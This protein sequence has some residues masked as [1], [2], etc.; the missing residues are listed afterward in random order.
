MEVKN[1][2]DAQRI[3]SKGIQ[4]PEF[5]EQMPFRIVLADTV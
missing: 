1:L 5:R 2:D 3:T 4:R